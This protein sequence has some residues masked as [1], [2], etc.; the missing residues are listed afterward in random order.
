LLA[1]SILLSTSTAR[2][3]AA[4]DPA[5]PIREQTV[6]EAIQAGVI[7]T[8]P[9]IVTQELSVAALEALE[10]VRQ[11]AEAVARTNA[12]WFGERLRGIE[13]TLVAQRTE[14]LAELR[15]TNRVL[16][17]IVGALGG[18]G[19]VGMLAVAWFQLRTMR[20]FSE[21]AASMPAATSLSLI[22]PPAV[23][24]AGERHLA[25]GSAAEHSSA[26]F[27]G[28]LE[29][30]EQRIHEL[31]HTTAPT[32]TVSTAAPAEASAGVH[33]GDPQLKSLVSGA[34]ARAGVARP[35]PPDR[36]ALLLG[37][38]QALLNLGKAEEAVACFD[39]A[40][41]LDARNTEVLLRKGTA[42]EKLKRLE[43]AIECY[44]RA[45]ALDHSQTM[46]YLHKGAVCNRLSRFDEALAC[47]EQALRAHKEENLQP[48]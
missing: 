41:D 2:L 35:E 44:D 25:S 20:R 16:L 14:E 19:L 32:A 42:L 22:H 8:V 21:V 23:L 15:E 27:L 30:L 17:L 3:L 36:V 46:A 31:E 45:I 12:E 29:R 4:A 28:T 47:Y 5:E 6:G 40:L 43:D 10:R 9:N 7:S 39:E 1:S 26:R 48:A 37:K 11:Q 24:G 33:T 34:L 18:L 13:Q 38:G